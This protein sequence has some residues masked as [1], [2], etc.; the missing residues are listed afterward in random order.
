MIGVLAM[1]D[2][3]K[4]TFCAM[5]SRSP[6]SSGAGG[7]IGLGLLTWPRSPRPV[8]YTV[9]PSLS[10]SAEGE[11]SSRAFVAIGSLLVSIAVEMLS[12]RVL[13]SGPP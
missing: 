10:V 13:A 6:S 12:R 1:K 8:T 4:D 3:S 11:G 9:E 7:W 2:I 5:H